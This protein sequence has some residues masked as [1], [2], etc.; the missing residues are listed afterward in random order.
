MGGAEFIIYDESTNSRRVVEFRFRQGEES[1]NVIDTLF[2]TRV[3]HE[4]L[5]GHGLSIHPSVEKQ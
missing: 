3:L 2:A 1:K 5:G 4:S